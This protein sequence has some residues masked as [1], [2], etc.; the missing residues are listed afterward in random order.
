MTNT[1]LRTDTNAVRRVLPLSTQNLRYHVQAPPAAV[2]VAEGRLTQKS[3]CLLQALF[4]T[5][6]GDLAVTN[7][8]DNYFTLPKGTD[9]LHTETQPFCGYGAPF[10]N[11][12]SA[13]TPK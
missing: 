8:K 13:L 10:R 12:T 11:T 7:A 5:T 9:A 3:R 4:Y 6:A 1:R 2:S